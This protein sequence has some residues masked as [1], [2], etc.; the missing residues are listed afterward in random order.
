MK[1]QPSVHN[2]D[3]EK[4]EMNREDGTKELRKDSPV[5]ELNPRPTCGYAHLPNMLPRLDLKI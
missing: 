2:A 5:K 4:T 3:G 1:K